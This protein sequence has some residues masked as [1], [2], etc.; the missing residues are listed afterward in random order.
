MTEKVEKIKVWSP[1]DLDSNPALALRY[2][3]K[4]LKNPFE[5]MV[6]RIVIRLEKSKEKTINS[7]TQRRPWW[8][9]SGSILPVLSVGLFDFREGNGTPLQYSC[10]ESPMDGGAW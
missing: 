10:L 6:Q 5:E 2:F 8:P 1:T 9:S 7:T 4:F 3:I